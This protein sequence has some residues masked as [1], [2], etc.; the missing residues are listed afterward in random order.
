MTMDNVD[1]LIT[2]GEVIT[3]TERRHAT[4]A[5]HQGKV[6]ALLEP[7]AALPRAERTIAANGLYVLPGAIDPHT[8]IGGA[9]KV[10]R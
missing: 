2:G 7:H 6:A 4:V 3:H 1:L 10:A 5:I 8:H 9:T